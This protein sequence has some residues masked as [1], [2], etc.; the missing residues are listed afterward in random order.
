[1]LN[2]FIRVLAVLFCRQEEEE[3]AARAEY[4]ELLN[5]KKGKQE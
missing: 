5:I 4:P 3:A 2:P 1:M